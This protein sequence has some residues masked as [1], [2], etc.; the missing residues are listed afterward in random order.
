MFKIIPFYFVL[1]LFIGFLILYLI[2]PEPQIIIKNPSV[3]D[4]LSE[5]YVDDNKVCY[6]YKREE[7]ECP[8]K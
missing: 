4:E 1:S 7:V 3:N 8:K 6:R 5:L 2:F